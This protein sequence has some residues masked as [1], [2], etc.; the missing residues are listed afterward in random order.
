MA[1]STPAA[2]S[3]LDRLDST[4]LAVFL[5]VADH[6]GALPAARA[7]GRSQPAVSSRI[8]EL[9]DRLGTALFFRSARG[10]A[11][12]EAGRELVGYARRTRALLA[13]AERRVSHRAAGGGGRLVLAT[14][15]TPAAF[16]LAP[17]LADFA[18][19][20]DCRGI[21]LH[22]GNTEQVLAA[23]REGIAPL[24]VVEGLGRA[25]GV[26]L[27]PFLDDELVPVFAPDRAD[28]ELRRA[29]SAVG[30]ALDLAALPILWRESGSGTRRVVEQALARAGVPLS[31]LRYDFVL[32]GTLAIKAAA[33]AGLGVAFL[34]RCA[35]EQ[36]LAL[37]RLVPV[38]PRRGLRIARQF[39]WAMPAGGVDEPMATFVRFA[40]RAVTG[41]TAARPA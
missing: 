37:Q 30:S 10:M 18:A 11:L 26:S 24:G 16:V 33:L 4:A 35:I 23:V 2:I 5:A 14:S 9:E 39:R 25:S 20:R 1:R 13:E 22:V 21:D 3:P 32:G 29:A 34:P 8:R 19:R 36:E 31:A 40:Q 27:Q 7:I 6:G 38:G 41:R 17:L 28:P 15:T 12:T